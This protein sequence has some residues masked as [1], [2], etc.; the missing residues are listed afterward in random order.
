MAPEI[1]ATGYRGEAVAG[2]TCWWQLCPRRVREVP[3]R[4]D[5][6]HATRNARALDV[7]GGASLTKVLRN[8]GAVVPGDPGPIEPLLQVLP[9]DAHRVLLCSQISLTTGGWLRLGFE[10]QCFLNV[11]FESEL[12]Q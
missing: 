11:K 5:V 4:L 1:T 12:L 7:F 8:D 9:D 10:A 6:V 2:R 3:S